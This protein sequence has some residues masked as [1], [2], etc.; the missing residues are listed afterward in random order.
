L[1]ID[2]RIIPGKPQSYEVV[3]VRLTEDPESSRDSAE[4]DIVRTCPIAAQEFDEIMRLVRDARLPPAPPDFHLGFDGTSF[5]VFFGDQ[6]NGSRYS[7]WG[8]APAEW[9]PLE[10]LVDRILEYAGA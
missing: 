4:G 6:L 2:D 10:Q 8:T 5:E 3:T 1:R 7:W 9:G